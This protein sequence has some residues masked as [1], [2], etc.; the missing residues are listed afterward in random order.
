MANYRRQQVSPYLLFFIITS[1]QIGVGVLGFQRIIAKDAGYDA[2]ISV[3]IAGVFVHVVLWFMFKLLSNAKGDI[4][5]AHTQLFGKIVG[6]FFSLIILLY[7]IVA[8]ISVLRLYIEIIQVWMFPTIQ[9]W[10][11]GIII[12]LLCYYI[13][14]GGFRVVVGMAF[15][16]GIFTAVLYTLLFHLPHKYIHIDNI[17]PILDHSFIDL[18]KSAKQSN[19]TMAGFEILL[20]VFPFIRNAN[21]CQKFAQW[22]VGFSTL[23]FTLS[24]FT[25]F[26]LLS[27][28]QI[29]HIIWSRIYIAKL[30]QFPFIERFEYILISTF[31]IKVISI[32]TLLLWSSSRGIK[33][34]FKWKQ[35]YVLI[36]IS[37]V[38][39]IVCQFLESRN[40]INSFTDYT[41]KISLC[42]FYIYIPILSIIYMFKKSGK[43]V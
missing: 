38:I 8:A 1:S 22:G 34:I 11:L 7:F 13:I 32:L 29:E 24:A 15:L 9:T 31:L 17:F 42:L 27:E 43:A 33:L 3:L 30:I 12:L 37:L 5:D 40:E 20:M 23:I 19:Y 28:K 14:S 6:S 39:I 21:S 4:I 26:L 36:I 35:K 25:T 41:S 10:L 2:W 18:M 16:S